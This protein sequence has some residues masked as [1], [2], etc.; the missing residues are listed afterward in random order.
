M[1]L[2]S[3]DFAFNSWCGV[4][5]TSI[6]SSIFGCFD[7]HFVTIRTRTGS[8]FITRRKSG[9]CNNKIKNSNHSL[10]L[11]LILK[12]NHEIFTS[13]HSLKRTIGILLLL[14][15]AGSCRTILP[16]APDQENLSVAP[17]R[18]QAINNS[19]VVPIELNLSGYFKDANK[20]VPAV[21]SGS[22]R[23][24][25]G[26]RYE[27][28]FKKDSFN[29][30][31]VNNHLLSELYGSYWIK[32]EYCAAC[33]D[34]LSSKPVCL[35]PIV[36]FSCGINEQKP[37]LRIRLATDLNIHKNYGLSTKTSIEELKPIN[38]CEVTVFRFDATD[39][40]IKE[41]RKTVKKQCEATDRELSSISFRKEADELWKNMNQS[42]KIPY[43]GYIHFEP[44]SVALVKPRLDQNKL[45][46]TL[47]LNC[48]T[49]LNQNGTKSAT[50]ELPDLEI[51]PSAPKDTFD[52][53]TDFELDYDS[54]SQLFT[55]QV[56]G[57]T[58]DF[59]KNHF[60]FNS[61]QV[62]GL[63]KN[64]LLLAIRFSGTK[65]GVLYLQGVPVF[66]NATKVLELAQLEYDLKTK[67]LLLKSAKWLFSNRIYTEL[68]K[69]TS[70]NLSTQFN[71][72]KKTMDKNLQK[73]AG[74]FVLTGKTHD[75][76]VIHIYPTSG[77]L[78]L[79]TCLK[80]QL[81]VK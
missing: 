9:E 34:L 20:S 75:I 71:Q 67:S 14:L 41:V 51:I 54:I 11:I 25:S 80:A 69:A 26:I 13:V 23:P 70:L 2:Q 42:I 45:Y 35:S 63:D 24:C 10:K 17:P 16:E 30:S 62:S 29:I 59:K 48:K 49:Y 18:L 66:D 5:I 36:P 8:F 50:P 38:P 44:V 81:S 47:V 79:R 78:Y 28:Q 33:T 76:S 53:F 37:S 77:H 15:L 12:C 56:K 31:T 55:E 68:E 4:L 57:K 43:L 74:E 21:T 32:M 1:E 52:L 46:T 6:L 27:F 19:V 22:D 58:I 7:G 60:E 40:V 3:I 61:V 72:L 39:E 65:K 64:K 73:K